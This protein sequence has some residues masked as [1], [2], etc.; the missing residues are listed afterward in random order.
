MAAYVDGQAAEADRARL[1]THAEICALCRD[2]VAAQRAMR[3]SLCARRAGLRGCASADLK[4]RCAAARNPVVPFVP[5]EPRPDRRSVVRRWMPLTAAATLLL[6]VAAVFALG[7]G[8][9]AGALAAQ[10]TLDHAKCSRYGVGADAADPAAE[11]ARWLER[12][13]WSIKV[14]GGGGD[15]PLEL[16][17][18]R[19]CAVIDGRVAHVIYKWRG[20]PL[21]LYV[22]PSARG[23]A[24]PTFIRRFGHEAV[25]WSQNNRTYV[26][27]S[28]GRRDPALHNVVAYVRA[29]AY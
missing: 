6:A 7:L 9:R 15:D 14:P 27:V 11:A 3:E 5:A 28:N 25:M 24:L 21:S 17:A 29:H 19:R 1:E 18:V 23:D 16:R 20:E 22:L 10:A 4:A 13:G 2:R 12:F 26:L 8:D